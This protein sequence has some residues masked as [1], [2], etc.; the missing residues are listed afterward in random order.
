MFG[1]IQVKIQSGIQFDYYYARVSVDSQLLLRR[2]SPVFYILLSFINETK[3]HI[4]V[5]EGGRG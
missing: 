3:M 5:H 4:N 2:M 1:I